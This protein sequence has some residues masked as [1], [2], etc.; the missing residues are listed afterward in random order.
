M[1]RFP[2]TYAGRNRPA[3]PTLP[4]ASLCEG[5]WLLWREETGPGPNYMPSCEELTPPLQLC[6]PP[7]SHRPTRM[8]SHCCQ[9]RSHGFCSCH[10]ATICSQWPLFREGPGGPWAQPCPSPQVSQ[11][12]PGHQDLVFHHLLAQLGR[13]LYGSLLCKEAGEKEGAGALRLS[14]GAED[15]GHPHLPPGQGRAFPKAGDVSPRA[16]WGGGGAQG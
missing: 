1:G 15:P 14:R 3:V 12:F 10:T 13:H 2:G 5:S 8:S 9:T 7:L 6:P 16:P 4:P 11:S